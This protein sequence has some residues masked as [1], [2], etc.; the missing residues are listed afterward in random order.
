MFASSLAVNEFLA[1]LHPYREETNSHYAAVEF[2]LAS[3]ELF[4]DSDQ[5]VCNRFSTKVGIGDKTPLLDEIELT[6]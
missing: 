5:G 4:C 1:R 3:M 2:S 6:L